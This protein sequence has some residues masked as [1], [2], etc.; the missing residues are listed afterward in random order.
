MES[1]IALLLLYVLI[2]CG[3][4][5]SLSIGYA[6]INTFDFEQTDSGITFSVIIPFRNEEANLHALLDSIS[7]LNYPK[8][9]FELIFVDD[10]S[11]D[12]SVNVINKWRLQNGKFQTTLLENLRISGSPKKDAISR[13]V[14]IIQNKWIVTTDADCIVPP[15]WLSALNSY[16]GSNDVRMIAGPVSYSGSRSFLHHFQRLDM[17]SLQAATI[18]GFGLHSGFMCNG[19]NFAYTKEL[20]CALGGFSSNDTIPGGDDVFLLQ[21]A[22][23]QFPDQVHYLKSQSSV[24]VTKPLNSWTALFN[25]RVRWASK[26]SDYNSAFGEDLALAVFLGNLAVVLSIGFY[27]VGFI[28]WQV[29]VVLFMLK[30][31]T[32]TVLLVQANNF[33]R[34]ATVFHGFISALLYPFFCVGVAIYSMAGKFEWKG[35]KY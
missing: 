22:V 23:T 7:Q 17:I 16:I 10:F 14:P 5:V 25:Q 15:N 21:N 1:I 6:K 34:C 30:I 19:A 26:T 32:D 35:R 24:V 28:G 3:F 18:G 8:D 2:Y 27:C 29:P 9:K 13:A 11:D 4:I 20:F 12:F 31:I 33:F